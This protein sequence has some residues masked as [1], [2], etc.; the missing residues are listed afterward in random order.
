MCRFL[1]LCLS[2]FDTRN[3]ETRNE[4]IKTRKRCCELMLLI[5]LFARDLVGVREGTTVVLKR[6]AFEQ[7]T[8]CGSAAHV[9]S[10][11]LD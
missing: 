4:K 5:S 8:N 11:N 9:F 6:G 10:L 7:H 1:L 3:G 2:H